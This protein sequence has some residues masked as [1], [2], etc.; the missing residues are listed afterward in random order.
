MELQ[1]RAQVLG[2]VLGVVATGIDV[3]FVRDFSRYQQIE[4]N[5]A[6]LRILS[7]EIHQQ[8][9]A[10]A[11]AERTLQIAT[12]RYKLGIDPY[13]NVITAQTALFSNRQTA[14]TLRSTQMTASVQLIEALGGSW[15][16]S[17]LPSMRMVS[18]AGTPAAAASAPAT[19]VQNPPPATNQ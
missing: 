14:V 11:S 16:T 18:G 13:L 2:H 10:V 3:K 9:V 4:D 19:P 8:D 5:L 6:S 7:V 15:D 12:D 17:Q 1:Q